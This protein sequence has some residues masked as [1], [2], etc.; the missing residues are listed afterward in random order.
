MPMMQR[1]KLR[2]D[3]FLSFRGE[4]MRNGFTDDLYDELLARDVRVFRDDDRGMK[5]GDQISPSFLAAI[6]ESAAAIT[7]I[8]PRYVRPNFNSS[9]LAPSTNYDCITYYAS[10]GWCLEELS[11][12]RDCGILILPVFYKVEPSDVRR[13]NG[14]FANDFRA[15]Q[16]KYEPEKME[17]W[18]KAMAHAGG[19]SG[20]VIK[21]KDDDHAPDQSDLELKHL[22][23]CLVKRVLSEISNSPMVVAPY[24]VGL[25]SPMK[26]VM[27]LLEI[28]SNSI[29]IIGLVGMGGIGKTTLAKAIYNKVVNSFD[30]LCFI[31]N[32]RET[33]Q[34]QDG[35][36]S[37]QEMLLLDLFNKKISLPDDVDARKAIM[38]ES[39][40]VKRVFIVLDDV[41]DSSQLTALVAKKWLFS[42]SKI[43]ITSRDKDALQQCSAD[44]IYAV[45]ELTIVDSLKLL[46]YHALR[47]EK[48]STRNF[49]EL[50]DTIVS[51]A[52]RLPLALEIFGSFLYDK[53]SVEEWKDAVKKLKKIRPDGLQDVLKISFDGLDDQTKCIFLDIACFLVDLEITRDEAIN[54]F[55]GCGLTGIKTLIARSLV[56][57]DEGDILVMH[58]QIR[59]MG[60]QIVQEE[61]PD[62]SI[63]R[64]RLWDPC[65]IMNVIDNGM[66][67]MENLQCIVLDFMKKNISSISVAPSSCLTFLQEFFL[68]PKEEEGLMLVN[69]KKLKPMVNLRLLHI[70][71]NVKLKGDLPPRVRWLKWR[72]CPLN[73]LPPSFFPRE[74]T[75]LHLLESKIDSLCWNSEVYLITICIFQVAKNLMVL[76]L[77]GCHNLTS[78]HGLSMQ[79]TSLEKVIIER[80]Y[81]LSM[82]HISMRTTRLLRYL[83]LSDC[84]SLVELFPCKVVSGLR[85]LEV[86]ILSGCS[87][88]EQLPKDL[89]MMTS[90]KELLLDRTA[91]KKLPDSI[92]HLVKLEKLDLS[93]CKFLGELPICLGHL[94][95]LKEF[96]LNGS[97]VKKIPQSIEGLKNLEK[98]N[99]MWCDSLTDI[100]DSIGNLRWLT[101]LSL[102]GTPLKELPSSIGSLS[103]LK[104]L[105]AGNCKLLN[106][107]PSSI[108]RFVSLESLELNGTP[109]TNLPDEIGRLK[110]LVKLEILNSE[111]LETLPKSIGDILSLETLLIGSTKLKELPESIGKLEN[112]SMLRLNQCTN[113]I[114]LP[115]S[116]VNMRS[117]HNFLME[118]TAVSELPEKFGM[119]TNLIVLKMGK[120]PYSEQAKNAKEA[121]LPSS[122]SKLCKLEEFNARSC[123]LVGGIP[124]DFE[125]LSRL[126]ILNLGHNYGICSLPSS[127]K[128]LGFLKK[129][130]I[131][132]CKEIKS[133]PPLPSSLE[134][135]DASNCTMLEHISD[136]SNLEYLSELNFT[137]CGKL[138]NIPGLECLKSLRGL[139]MVCCKASW[140]VVKEKLNKTMMNNLRHLSIPGS[141][142]P[143]WLGS[144]VVYF[145]KKQNNAIIAVI[146]AVVMCVKLEQQDRVLPVIPD[147]LARIIR[148][149]QNI[150]RKVFETA[151]EIKVQEK[152][153][154]DHLYLYRHSSV[155]PL[156]SML[157]DGDKIEVV[158]RDPPYAQGVELKGC[159][160]KLVFENDDDYIGDE[161][162][163]DETQQSVSQRLVKSLQSTPNESIA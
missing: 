162:F 128:G 49:Q 106:A 24:P 7:I 53:R 150:N 5:Q 59:D 138:E 31:S 19:L 144:D 75:V 109:I 56:K 104:Q 153:D 92:F 88:F 114:K 26:E 129:L 15:L 8:S 65:Q 11:T 2:W 74:L 69:A 130:L 4:D 110:S 108:E 34:R 107:L 147:I 142:I 99:L 94:S 51:L 87:K 37:L 79:N 95:S 68:G 133:L 38:E 3:F 97:A 161:R 12:I 98:L 71:N 113:L 39:F 17:R 36:I 81:N 154:E 90:L 159:G 131:P 64:T 10:S 9:N 73:Y 111:H 67:G 160:I 140:S 27:R 41:D 163:L 148:V 119:L 80:C 35:L 158:K 28:K 62:L 91:I 86:L 55:K 122:F 22:I 146:I 117:L 143:S 78:I 42:G 52:G 20:W 76:N 116:I 137:N 84:T 72:G 103:Y 105:S 58:D 136:L 126:E 30:S 1:H 135:I 16:G 60:R 93:R 18:R 100:P 77:Y 66:M 61:N 70:N 83:N 14:T 139:Y 149:K 120:K 50:S 33:F 29:K 134:E 132:H 118:N 123:N 152:M 32:V 151:L 6:K 85:N 89:G 40:N 96:D 57:V 13:Q 155:L 157:R 44:N 115:G 21:N 23:Q 124:D 141:E 112:L 45:T 125:S 102:N 47:Q 48:P 145:R 156:V 25:T 127:L 43:L 46:S 82:I 101:K 54:I 63:C 121:V